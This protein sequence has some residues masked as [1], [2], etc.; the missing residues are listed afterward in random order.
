MEAALLPVRTNVQVSSGFV[1]QGGGWQPV[2]P[3]SMSGMGYI[4]AVG[5]RALSSCITSSL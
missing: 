2:D 5:V 1:N 3:H 4:Q